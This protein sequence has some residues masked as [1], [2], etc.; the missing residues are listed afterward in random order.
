MFFVCVFQ[1]LEIITERPRTAI[2]ADPSVSAPFDFALPLRLC[3]SKDARESR[4]GISGG[5][6][7]LRYHW[8]RLTG[9]RLLLD[10]PPTLEGRGWYVIVPFPSLCATPPRQTSTAAF[11][12]ALTYSN[13]LSY[14][15]R[16]SRVGRAPH[17]EDKHHHLLLCFKQPVRR[18]AKLPAA[19][20]LTASP[21]WLPSNFR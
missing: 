10:P 8:T 1:S 7:Q 2:F 18:H 11:Q 4:S 15:A 20:H 12:V 19:L 9:V 14:H 13:F 3:G 21:A 6:A 17:E 16:E 5:V